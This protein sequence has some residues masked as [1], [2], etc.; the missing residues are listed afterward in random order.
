MKQP[1]KNPGCFFHFA[2]KLHRFSKQIAMPFIL[3]TSNPGHSAFFIG[4]RQPLAGATADETSQVHLGAFE[5]GVC[6]TNNNNNNKVHITSH[7]RDFFYKQTLKFPIVPR[8]MWIHVDTCKRRLR[9][10]M[11]D[12][13]C[14]AFNVLSKIQ[15]NQAWF[16]PPPRPLQLPWL[17]SEADRMA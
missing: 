7:I 5:G 15:S 8:W 3:S 12:L 10:L 1:R 2:A 16:L 17:E 14:F 6:G 9:S 13:L 4:I 11:T